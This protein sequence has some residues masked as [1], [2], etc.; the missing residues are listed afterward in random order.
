MPNI[1]TR[2]FMIFMATFITLFTAGIIFGYAGMCVCVLG[3]RGGLM[4]TSLS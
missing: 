2:V 1:A 4:T 3:G